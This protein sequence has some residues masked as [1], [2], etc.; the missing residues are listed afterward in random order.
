[1]HQD[2]FPLSLPPGLDAMLR[3]LGIPSSY[4]STCGMP[5]Q[6]ECTTLV[7]TE[8]D[9]F[10]RQPQLD[11]GAYAAWTAMKEAAARDGITL[12][13][14]SAFRS[15][16]YQ[17]DLIQRKLARGDSIAAILAVNAAP[18]FSEHHTGR[19]VDIGTPGFAHLE[20]EF[21]QS[22][23]FAW[24]TSRAR[25]FSFRMSFPRGN[26]YGVQYEPWHWCYDAVALSESDR[27]AGG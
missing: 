18:G 23:A 11:A 7:L 24:L 2:D 19:A 9:V 13:L 14:V 20:I 6:M 4:A 12:Q 10:G 16:A 8:P 25:E 15:I 22:P 21:E 3:S 5:P 26:P 27:S 17:H 1:M